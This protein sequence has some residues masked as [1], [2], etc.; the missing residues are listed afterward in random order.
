MSDADIDVGRRYFR[1]LKWQPCWSNAITTLGSDKAPLY[2]T[3]DVAK[4]SMLGMYFFLEMFTIVSHEVCKMFLGETDQDRRAMLSAQLLST[5]HRW[6]N[7]KQTSPGSTLCC[8]QS[9][10]HCMSC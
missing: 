1:L 9:W 8:S 3:L 6:Y 7:E 10:Y 5:G 2:K 4:W